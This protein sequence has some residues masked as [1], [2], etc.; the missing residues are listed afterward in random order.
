M[1]IK[2]VSRLQNIGRNSMSVFKTFIQGK[3]DDLII[4]HD[5]NYDWPYNGSAD[6][7]THLSDALDAWVLSNGK[8]IR[9]CMRPC[10]SKGTFN[11]GIIPIA[12][13]K[14]LPDKGL[15]ILLALTA[16]ENGEWRIVTE[17]SI[18]DE[19]DKG[20]TFN[21][22]GAYKIFDIDM[23]RNWINTYI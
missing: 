14:L 11:D 19:I 5:F 2:E 4:K 22:W 10:I 8:H 20:T 12:F 3:L 23:L 6:K 16:I 7:Y 18:F 21:K 13:C 9:I 1:D 15:P 17:I